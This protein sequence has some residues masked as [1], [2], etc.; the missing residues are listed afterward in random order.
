MTS[1][2]IN[3][4]KSKFDRINCW[5]I[6]P[7]LGRHECL[8]L[9]FRKFIESLPINSYLVIDADGLFFLCKHPDLLLIL[10]K[11]HCIMT[12]NLR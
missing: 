4:F 10:E 8:S 11:I 2:W 12:P 1:K 5:V 6:G 7:G 9:F 3:Y